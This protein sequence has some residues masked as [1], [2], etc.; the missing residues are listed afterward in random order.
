MQVPRSCSDTTGWP[1]LPAISADCGQGAGGTACSNS[2]PTKRVCGCGTTLLFP[3]AVA[4]RTC[5]RCGATLT[6]SPL[7][8][9]V[10]PTILGMARTQK[11]EGNDI[12]VTSEQDQNSDF[13]RTWVFGLLATS[14]ILNLALPLLWQGGAFRH[15]AALGGPDSDGD[16]VPDKDDFCPENC[17]LGK[18]PKG[19]KC[20]PEGWVS[21]RAT[22]FDGDGCEDGVA[23]LDKDNDG[24][25]DPDDSCPLT[26]QRY[27]F[28]SN[29][30]S[31][32]DGDG[33][34][35]G[36]EDHDDDGDAVLNALDR[37]PRTPQQHDADRKGCSRLQREDE[38]LG[39][40]EQC[41]QAQ[42]FGEREKEWGSRTW[43]EVLDE[44]FAWFRSAWVE[45]LM[46]GALTSL[47][48]QVFQLTRTLKQQLPTVPVGSVRIFTSQAIDAASRSGRPPIRMLV[49]RATIYTVF[50]IVVYSYRYCYEHA[51]RRS[52][53]L[54]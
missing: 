13:G 39:V 9:G 50:F 17:P 49:V 38:A 14:L 18:I 32:F 41:P 16:G 42:V 31:D 46:G 43:V 35:D 24:I 5:W 30:Q 48:G 40:A 25:S 29:F 36:V 47:T 54:V 22:D 1:N 10:E 51:Q 53:S 23:D 19:R 12:I 45:V 4:H 28:M 21:G 8:P 52:G 15:V 11:D 3:G 20:S 26:P 27:E 6:I 33:C 34:A 44:N 2:T 7:V 37:C